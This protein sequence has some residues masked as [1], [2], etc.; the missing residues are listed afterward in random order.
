MQARQAGAD[1]SAC[2]A[3][4]GAARRPEKVRQAAGQ[5]G[6][7]RRSG[8]RRPADGW[9]GGAKEE[10]RMAEAKREFH[11]FGPVFDRSS[12]ILILGSFPSVKSREQAFYY[13]HPQNR[14]WKVLAALL[15]APVP[16][17]IGEKKQLLLENGIALW[18][19]LESCEIRG[20]SDASIRGAVPVEIG[21]ITGQA[22]IGAI[23]TNGST[24]K[25]YYDRL[26]LPVTGRK[27]VLLPS[28]SPANAAWTLSRLEERWGEL[29][30]PHLY[31]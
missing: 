16:E 25:R 17:T 26:L 24:A 10:R 18:D 29:I 7:Q 6:G 30:R 4:S 27:A 15:S 19:V 20:S 23:F 21:R 3:V 9:P 2:L 13:G 31:P 12:R 14:F 5:R 8:R 11:G 28:T 1:T 22:Q